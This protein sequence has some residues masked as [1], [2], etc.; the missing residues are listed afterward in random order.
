MAPHKRDPE[1]EE[2]AVQE[3]L[4]SRESFQM[5]VSAQDLLSTQKAPTLPSMLWPSD[6]CAR[7]G[8]TQAA[9]RA[10]VRA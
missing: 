10:G 5:L 4:R 3:A 1:R 2:T 9:Q 6:C 8:R 7:T